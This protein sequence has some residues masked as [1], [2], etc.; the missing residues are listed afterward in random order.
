MTP[1]STRTVVLRDGMKYYAIKGRSKGKTGRRQRVKYVGP[2][3]VRMTE[4]QVE[5]FKDLLLTAPQGLANTTP[6]ALEP[7]EDEGNSEDED[8]PN[9]KDTKAG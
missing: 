9:P 7:D 5:N 3:E 1:A 4:D 8:A 2:C 6:V